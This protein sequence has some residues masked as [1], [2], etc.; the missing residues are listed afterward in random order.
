MHMTPIVVG[1]GDGT[2][3]DGPVGGPVTFKVRAAQ[4]DGTLTAYENVV[5]PGDGPP[6][7][8]HRAEDET[9]W[10]IDG[11]LRFRLGDEVHSA[12]TGSFL[13]IPRGTPHCFQNVGDRPARVMVLLTP[14]GMEW[15]LERLAA[16]GPDDVDQETFL[17][18]MREEG[19]DV[20]GP[21]L[22]V[23]HPL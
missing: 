19:M 15:F 18:L 4:T 11:A 8:V 3:I 1:P 2:T 5:A 17:T 6:C 22:A 21:P 7:H 10:V 13:F 23:S 16:L 9:F 14:S 12:P 20:V